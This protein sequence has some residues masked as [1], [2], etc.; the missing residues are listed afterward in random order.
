MRVSPSLFVVASKKELRV[1]EYLR[2]VPPFTPNTVL[3]CCF[4]SSYCSYKDMPVYV[5]LECGVGCVPSNLIA[6]RLTPGVGPSLL[7]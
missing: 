6:Q 7:F 5:L 3:F 2:L 4:L 1:A